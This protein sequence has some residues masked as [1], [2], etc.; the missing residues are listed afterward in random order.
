MIYGKPLTCVLYFTSR[1]KCL[2]KKK[3]VYVFRTSV[4]KH[5]NVKKH[6]KCVH[7]DELF[8]TFNMH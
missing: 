8:N 3:R 5:R 6:L 4:H 1:Y 2:N 7:V